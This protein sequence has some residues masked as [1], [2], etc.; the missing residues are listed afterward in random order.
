MRRYALLATLLLAAC[1]AATRTPPQPPHADDAPLRLRVANAEAR[2]AGGVAELVD[3]AARGGKR[4]RLLALRGLGRIGATGG[5]QVIASLTAALGDADAEVAGAAASAIGVA[6]S[7][8]DAELG[9]TDAL[10]AALPRGGGPVVEALGRA[11]TAAAQPALVGLLGD[12]KL[13]ELAALALG[14]HGRRKIELTEPSRGALVAATASPDQ[15]VRYAAVYALA[16]EFQPPAHPA[17]AAALTARIADP[18]AEIRAQ[19]IAGLGRRKAV[20]EA[21]GSGARLD[22]LLLD[23]D[24][25]VAVEAVRALGDSDDGKDAIAAAIARRF[26]ELER[27]EPTAAHVILEGE[28]ALAGAARR[29]L[30]EAALG[31]LATRARAA[32][33]IPELTRGWIACLAASATARAQPDPDLTAV[34]QCPL[35][36]HLRLPLVAQLID[37]EAGSLAS[38]RAALARLLGHGDPRVRAAGLGA[39]APLWK[40]GDA[41]DRRNAIATLTGALASS[42]SVVAG[43]AVDAATAVYEV[44]GG[45]DAALDAAVIAR[46]TTERDPELGAALLELIGKRALAAGA[47]ACRGALAGDPVRAKA[48]ASCLK[49]LGEA[50]P[51][52]PP[53]AAAAPPVDV[54]AVVGKRLRWRV[55]TSRGD[56]VIALHPDVAPWAVAT[57]V[58]LTRKH[59]YDGI[60]FH[61]VVPNF[62]VQGGDPTES[63]TGGP[64]FAIPAEPGALG[65]GVGYLAGGVGIADAGRDSGGSQWF[66]M[67]SRAPHLDGRYTWI[68]TVE[69]GQK[70]ADALLIGDR[71]V[72][73]TIESAP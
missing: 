45:G 72:R 69:S 18:V 31:E 57:I 22:E 4:E 42:D 53:A 5:A 6:A 13:A 51:A 14:R 8:D 34:E 55:A 17:A 56:V 26:A 24:W 33:A 25:R 15:A 3:L 61:R 73:A 10:I 32:T 62:V 2:R 36:D 16:R 39:L 58:A 65:D 66:V 41:A 20:A 27:G 71:V 48:A 50:P 35:P 29:P 1:P 44:I 30:V 12:P 60:E 37:A 63:G 52:A 19:A 38:R 43:A 40:A 54:A 67:H 70:S 68:G 11:G 64:G 21:R 46:A 59:F 9:A 23:R 7:L 28:R 49:A 47:A